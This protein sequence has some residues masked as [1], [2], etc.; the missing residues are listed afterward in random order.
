MKARQNALFLHRI[1][2]VDGEN[3]KPV[4]TSKEKNAF[5]ASMT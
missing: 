3:R 4:G 5:L 2:Q 1:Q